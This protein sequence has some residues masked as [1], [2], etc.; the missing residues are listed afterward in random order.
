[1]AK[2]TFPEELLKRHP[3]LAKNEIKAIARIFINS[4]NNR[5]RNAYIVDFIIPNLGR[6]KSHGNKVVRRKKKIMLKDKMRKRVAHRKKTLT[7][8]YL[9]F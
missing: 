9:L 7:K 5:L 1:M 3:D 8:E 4:K 6:F 2:Q